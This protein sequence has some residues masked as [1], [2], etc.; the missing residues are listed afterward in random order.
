MTKFKK[1]GK[2]QRVAPE[3]D[4]NFSTWQRQSAMQGIPFSKI[5]IQR[6]FAA[7]TKNMVFRPDLGVFRDPEFSDRNLLRK[8]KNK[9]VFK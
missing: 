4:R 6:I 7:K 3:L 8:S 9:D 5:D 1:R 2:V